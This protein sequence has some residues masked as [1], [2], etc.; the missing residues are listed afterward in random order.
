[1]GQIQVEI[2]NHSF[3]ICIMFCFSSLDFVAA[4]HREDLGILEV[5]V[6][7]DISMHHAGAGE[8]ILKLSEVALKWQML[9]KP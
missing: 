6:E 4:T 5:Q 1:M 8:L 2:L 9:K 3:I 7:V